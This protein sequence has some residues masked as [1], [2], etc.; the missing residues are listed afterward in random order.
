MTSAYSTTYFH[1][2]EL[3]GKPRATAAKRKS[4]SKKVVVSKKMKKSHTEPT[5]VDRSN[6]GE[7]DEEISNESSPKRSKSR[8]RSS[9]GKVNPE[10]DGD[11]S[12]K[13]L[14]RKSEKL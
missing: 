6:G 4:A 13:E 3:K 12:E 10:N 7:T 8:K 9:K 5:P 2:E 1:E 11:Y 14:K